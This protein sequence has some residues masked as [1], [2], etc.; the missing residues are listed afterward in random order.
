MRQGALL[1]PE[2]GHSKISLI[3][4]EPSGGAD[5]AE[6][7]GKGIVLTQLVGGDP[8]AARRSGERG[9]D[10]PI[11]GHLPFDM[12]EEMDI[13]SQRFQVPRLN[14]PL[15]QGL[16]SL[17]GIQTAV[18]AGKFPERGEQTPIGPLP[19]QNSTAVP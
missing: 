5:A 1:Q 9:A 14:S 17:S 4:M 2:K 16:P 8:G 3:H 11:G 13:F 18:A 15:L 7:G 19:Q 12:G 6:S 10:C